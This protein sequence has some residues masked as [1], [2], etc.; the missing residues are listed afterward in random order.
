MP[1]I[2][3]QSPKTTIPR[4]GTLAAVVGVAAASLLLKVIPED[5]SGRK[6]DV[7]VAQDG[8]ATVTHISGRQYL[9][10]YLD[11][12]GV[13][14]AC[15]GLT[16]YGG[17]RIVKGQ[18]FTE[19]QCASALEQELVQH[20]EIVMACSSFDKDRQPYQIFAAVSMQYNTG[21]WCGS[22]ANKRMKAGN[23]AGGCDALLMWN[24]AGGRIVTGLV[25]RRNRE[26][27]YCI[28]G[29]LPTATSAN[30]AQRVERWR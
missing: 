25:N 16:R 29:V 7:H 27:E 1:G 15:D 26:R 2:E 6:V 17:K 19:A 9:T 20:A 4:K 18:K 22:T 21:G 10:A 28:T 11:I 23:I 12:V 3:P 5:E 14:T 24:K 13:A 30:L 8:T